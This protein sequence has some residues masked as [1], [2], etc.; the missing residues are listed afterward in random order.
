MEELMSRA[1]LGGGGMDPSGLLVSAPEAERMIEQ[2]KE[3]PLEA[4]GTTPWMEQHDW[5]EKLNLQAHHNAQTHSDE[6][7]MESLVSFDKISTLVHEL[8]AIEVWKGKVM[9]YLKKHLANKVDSV[10]SYLLLY[11]EATVANLLEVSLY[12]S[13][14]AEACSED[15]MLELVDWCHR[16]MIYLNNEGHRDANPPD[17]TKEQWMNQSSLEAFEEKQQEINFGVA[18]AA[19]SIQRYLTDHVKLLPLGVVGRMVNTCDV[20]MALVPLLDNPPW[21]RRRKG[22]TQKFVQNKWASVE[23]AERM[24]LTPADAQVWLAI[25]NLVVDPAF[26]EK[27]EFTQFRKDCLH[28][29]RRYMNELL[30]DQLPVLKDLQRAVDALTLGS[31]GSSGGGSASLLMEAVPMLRER[32]LAQQDWEGLAKRV[33]NTV[34]GA[35]GRDVAQ[36]RMENLLKTFEFMADMEA[37]AGPNNPAEGSMDVDL[38]AVPV[39]L[40]TRRKTSA[41]M[42]V[43][44]SEYTFHINTT[45]PAEPVELRDEEGRAVTGRRYRL[46]P[47]PHAVAKPMPAKGK[48]SVVHGSSVADALLELPAPS[49]KSTTAEF[50]ATVWL[51][52]GLLATDGLALQVKLRKNPDISERDRQDGEWYI[53]EPVGGA[54]TLLDGA[55]DKPAEAPRETAPGKASQPANGSAAPPPAKPSARKHQEVPAAAEPTKAVPAQPA[56]GKLAQEEAPAPSPPANAVTDAAEVDGFLDELD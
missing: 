25:N 52:V 14:A 46:A 24:K 11:H 10:T 12:H 56:V 9:P 38:T 20:L 26:T 16:K 53:Y 49:T 40:E 36:K 45:K 3:Y 6:F 1:Q 55:L 32:L 35:A 43:T 51:T 2:L 7:V 15:A 17:K 54:I 4:V 50:P 29:L 21:V 8:L 47:I 31:G 48:V 44:Y 27:Y 18:M 34:F 37:S 39:K 13:H 41:G 22:E 33:K 23:R 30:F 28:S 5:I 42:W 19:L